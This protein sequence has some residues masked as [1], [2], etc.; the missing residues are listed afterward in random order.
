MLLALVGCVMVDAMCCHVVIHMCSMRTV[1]AIPYMWNH[2][3][4]CRYIC[5]KTKTRR[6]FVG[7][8]GRN[9]TLSITM[10]MLGG[11]VETLWSLFGK[12]NCI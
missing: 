3:C 10:N 5:I 8:G 4:P 2:G 9:L 12:G 7:G 1:N 6:E 11:N